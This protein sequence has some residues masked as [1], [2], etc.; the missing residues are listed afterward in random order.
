M[1]T[2]LKYS[3]FF[4]LFSTRAVQ[5]LIETLQSPDQISMLILCLKRGVV[6]LI[7]DLNG[8]HVVQ[9]C[10]QR[11]KNEDNQ[12][13]FMFTSLTL[14][15][16]MFMNLVQLLIEICLTFILNVM[17][18]F[19]FDAAASHCVEIASHRHGCCVLQRCVDFASGMQ[20]RQL[21]AE[22]ATNSLA[23]SQDQYG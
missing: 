12:V 14:E 7:K 4:L 15:K 21:V 3:M 19:I 5:K 10:L 9:R 6:T 8:N 20:Q 11:L 1:V 18:Q 16:L 17:E 2:G 13:K 22:I 23:L